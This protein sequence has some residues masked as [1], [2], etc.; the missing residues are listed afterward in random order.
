EA[1]AGVGEGQV[2]VDGFGHAD[3]GDGVA[4]A[5]ADLRDLVGGVLGI[6][7]AVI[8]EIA[9]VVG[10]EHLHQALVLA[11][12]FFE[13]TQLVAAGTEGTA[14]GVFQGGNGG[15]GFLAGVDHVFG[16]GTDDAIV[17]GIQVA[18]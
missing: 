9:D 10:P 2:V 17:A 14:G 8:E 16:E 4:H 13:G 7:A 18:N 1:G 6:T 12:V 5:L 11:A 15:G 3:A